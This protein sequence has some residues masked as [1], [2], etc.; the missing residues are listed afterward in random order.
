MKKLLT[1]EIAE[2]FFRNI[3]NRKKLLSEGVVSQQ[4]YDRELAKQ[5][6]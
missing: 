5:T 6:G 3:E 4:D 1:V 2:G